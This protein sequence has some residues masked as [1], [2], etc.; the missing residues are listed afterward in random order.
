MA[1]DLVH[2][3]KA[4]LIDNDYVIHGTANSNS[5]GNS[6]NFEVKCEMKISVE[7]CMN[8]VSAQ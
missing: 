6:L 5:C 8:E 1:V 7:K 3:Y 4:K 2:N